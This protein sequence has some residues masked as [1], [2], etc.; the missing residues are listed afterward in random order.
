M[1]A[2]M[3]VKKLDHDLFIVDVVISDA[4]HGIIIHRFLMRDSD[5]VVLRL[6]IEHCREPLKGT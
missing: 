2:S 6:L 5:V 4:D 1:H 3:E